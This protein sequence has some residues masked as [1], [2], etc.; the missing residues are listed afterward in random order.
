[1]EIQLSSKRKLGFVEGTEIRS[2]TETSE[3][4]QWDTCTMWKQLEKRFQLTHG[5]RK[6]K[7]SKELFGLKQNGARIVDYYTSL[8][9]LWGELDSMN[10]LPTV[11]TVSEEVSALLKAI[12]TQ[13]E[14]SHLFQFL[15]GLDESYGPLRSQLLMLSPLPSVE[16]ASVAIQQEESQRDILKNPLTCDSDMSAMYSKTSFN[17]GKS[18]VCGT[19]GG[20]GHSS[21][22]CWNIICY[23]RWHYKYKPPQYNYSS[24]NQNTSNARWSNQKPNFVS[25]GPSAAHVTTEHRHID[26][27]NPSVT[28]STQQLQQLLQLWPTQPQ[29]MSHESD[30]SHME[31]PFS[32]MISCQKVQTNPHTWIVDTGA[33]NHMTSNPEILTNVKLVLTHM[34]VNLPTGARTVVSHVGDVSLQNGLKLLNVLYVPT[35]THNLLFI[36]KLSQ[37]SGC[38]TVFS[39][40][41]CKIVESRTYEEKGIVSNVMYH[42]SNSAYKDLPTMTRSQCMAVSNQPLASQFTR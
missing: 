3:A 2:T 7:L 10:L 17:P 9:S 12:Q 33:T 42:M 32:G 15:N 30:D 28:L 41:K 22:K 24:R 36:H 25:K 35:F 39:P 8:I 16:M 13:K 5:S 38:F 20:K 19:C 31:S 1:M 27:N 4:V 29:S 37:D 40:T 26:P 21:D 11:T 6:Y 23:P 18:L 14:E 34:S